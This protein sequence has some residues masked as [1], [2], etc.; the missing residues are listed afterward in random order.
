MKL[1]VKI[2]GYIALTALLN[3]KLYKDGDQ[4]DQLGI[5]EVGDHLQGVG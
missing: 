2:R 3:L 5:F 4:A 1:H